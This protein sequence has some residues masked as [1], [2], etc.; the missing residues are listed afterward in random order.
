MVEPAGPPADTVIEPPIT[1]ACTLPS[2]LMFMVKPPP[3][4]LAPRQVAPCTPIES[5]LCETGIENEPPPPVVLP[6]LPNQSAACETW[7]PLM[8]SPSNLSLDDFSCTEPFRYL[9]K[10]SSILST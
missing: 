6:V 1:F 8:P 4:E 3:E 7:A 5:R 9:P 2:V 10:M